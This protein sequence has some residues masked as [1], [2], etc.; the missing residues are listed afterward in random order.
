MSRTPNTP[1]TWTYFPSLLQNEHEKVRKELENHFKYGHAAV[2]ETDDGDQTVSMTM[3][4]VPFVCAV[5]SVCVFSQSDASVV[6]QQTGTFFNSN[7]K[8]NIARI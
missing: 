8:K 6:L 3:I 5:F 2:A 1:A 4:T 7:K